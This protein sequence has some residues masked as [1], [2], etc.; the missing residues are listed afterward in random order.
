MGEEDGF[1]ASLD[2]SLDEGIRV[3]VLIL[4]E[5]GVE[6]FES[7]EGGEGHSFTEPTIR[8]H[9]SSWAGYHAFSVAMEHALPVCELQRAYDVNDGQL[10]GPYWKLIFG[11]GVRLTQRA[12]RPVRVGR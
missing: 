7:C 10:E 5:C 3:A 11:P 8:F 9:G 1:E 4:R 2:M 12:Q 6:T